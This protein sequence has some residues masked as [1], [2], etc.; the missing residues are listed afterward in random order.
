VGSPPTRSRASKGPTGRVK[1]SQMQLEALSQQLESSDVS[2][3]KTAINMVTEF[4]WPLASCL[5]GCR[6]VQ[7]AL[8]VASAVEQ[9]AIAD[10]IRGKVVQAS[11]CPHANYVLQKCVELLPTDSMS[12][13]LIEMQGHVVATARHRYGCRVLERLVE[14]GWQTENIVNEVLADACQ[15]CRHPFGNFVVQHVMKH[16]TPTQ[17]R[18]LVDV[19]HRDIHRLARHRVASHVVRCTL[20]HST[21]EERR[22]LVGTLGADMANLADLASHHCGSYIVREMRRDR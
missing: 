19:V 7:N 1:L 20:V 14:R 2:A 8:C 6:L 18:N 10:Q 5:N 22:A 12:F 15:L 11:T 21:A 16:G 3:K 17:R 9:A 4:A 13:I